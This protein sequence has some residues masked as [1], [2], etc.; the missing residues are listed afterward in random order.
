M[1]SDFISALENKLLVISTPNVKIEEIKKCLLNDNVDYHSL[2]KIMDI[3]VS[4][5]SITGN[6]EIIKYRNELFSEFLNF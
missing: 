6:E 2:Q 3:L 5:P 4:I 1:I